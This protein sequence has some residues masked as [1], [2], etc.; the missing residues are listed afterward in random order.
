MAGAVALLMILFAGF[1][2]IKSRGEPE[3]TKTAKRVLIA[4]IVGFVIV[5]LSQSMLS[6]I[7]SLLL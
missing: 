3:K 1:L 5:L 2:Y 4:A 7:R 6:I